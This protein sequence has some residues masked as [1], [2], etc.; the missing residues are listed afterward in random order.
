MPLN[1]LRDLEANLGIP[2][3]ASTQWEMVEQ[4]ADLIQPA[5]N[6]VIRQAARERCCTTPTRA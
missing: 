1:R 5:H 2:L 6:E 3:P 4:M